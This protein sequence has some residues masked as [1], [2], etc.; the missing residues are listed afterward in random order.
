MIDQLWVATTN[1]GKLAEFRAL[2]DGY[3]VGVHSPAELAV[4]SSPPET[5]DSFLANARIKAKALRALK[6]DQWVIGEDSGL[7]VDGLGGLPG[8]HSARYAGDKAS[9]PEN[10]AKLLK[11]LKIRSPQNRRARFR[12]LLVALSP[13]GEEFVF[14]GLLEGQ[15]SEVPKGQKGFGYDPVFIPEGEDKTLAE[16]PPAFKNK[17]SHR[18]QALR[19]W[20]REQKIIP[21]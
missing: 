8:I 7:E 6:A 11:M 19:Q 12:A 3:G 21:E 1:S 2:L 10:V 20:A 15:I 17:V 16:L 14:E 5:G 9:D 18:A 13:Q 4:Y